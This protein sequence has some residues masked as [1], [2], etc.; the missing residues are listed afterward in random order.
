LVFCSVDLCGRLKCKKPLVGNEGSKTGGDCWKKIDK[1]KY[2]STFEA[3]IIYPQMEKKKRSL[4][5]IINILS[6]DN[7]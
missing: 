7:T 4:L 6:E 2:D 5:I 3:G 1:V